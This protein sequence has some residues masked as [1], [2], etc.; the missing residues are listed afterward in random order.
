MK[1]NYRFNVV[2]STVLF[3]GLIGLS[4]SREMLPL[5]AINYSLYRGEAAIERLLGELETQISNNESLDKDNFYVS[6]SECNNEQEITL[7]YC[8]KCDLINL[9]NASNR[10]LILDKRTSLPVVFEGDK[11]HSNYIKEGLKNS[12]LPILYNIE[13]GDEIIS[14]LLKGMKEYKQLVPKLQLEDTDFYVA[15]NECAD[16]RISILGYCKGCAFKELIASTNRYL[17]ID[18]NLQL[19]VIFESDRQHSNFF[20]SPDGIRIFITAEGYM[21]VSDKENNIV[22]KGFTQY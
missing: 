10:F 20:S 18:E 3:L 4:S 19:P 21:V 8:D 22:S 12:S 17:V 13:E 9:I 6:F 15:Y 16:Q 7:N 5:K 1:N 2:L 14:E 11:I